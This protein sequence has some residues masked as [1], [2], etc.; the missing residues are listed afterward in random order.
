MK[1]AWGIQ[2]EPTQ[3]PE[4]ESKGLNPVTTTSRQAVFASY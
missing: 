1:Q 3:S 2:E 4:L